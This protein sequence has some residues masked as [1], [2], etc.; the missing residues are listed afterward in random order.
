M[1][2]GIW[3]KVSRRKV[4]VE[5]IWI[6]GSPIITLST[7]VSFELEINKPFAVSKTF[8]SS[9]YYYSWCTNNGTFYFLYLW[10]SEIKNWLVISNL[11]DNKNCALHTKNIIW[12]FMSISL[13][14]PLKSVP[15]ISLVMKNLETAAHNTQC[16]GLNKLGIT[17][18]DVPVLL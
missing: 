4:M 3:T 8:S 1:D 16:N 2:R 7:D 18:I 9:I 10:K 14:A 5:I 17:C 13:P 12:Y 11:I 15:M 6:K